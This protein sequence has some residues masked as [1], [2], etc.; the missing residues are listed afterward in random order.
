MRH[1]GFQR[2]TATTAT[3]SAAPAKETWIEQSASFIG[4][5]I[6]LLILK[7]FFLP[8]FIIPTGSMAETLYGAHART[9]CPNCGVEYSVGWHP[10]RDQLERGAYQPV[11]QCPNCRWRQYHGDAA[12]LA[13]DRVTPDG[14]LARPL[15]PSAGDRIFVHGWP[16]SEPFASI[17][18]LGPARWDVVVFKVP[19][20]GQTNYIKRL[21]GLPNEKIEIINGDL[22]VNDRLTPKTLQAQ[23]SLWFPVYSQNYPPRAASR[24]ADYY[25]RWVAVGPDTPWSGLQSRVLRCDAV[26]QPRRAIQFVTD[27]GGDPR[28][29]RIQDLYAYNE[30][31]G[32]ISPH[33]VSDVRLSAEV[34]LDPASRGGVELEITHQE[35][36][37]AASLRAD[38]VLSLVHGV[39]ADGPRETWGTVNVS[40][41]RGPLH[42]A[43]AHVDGLA[44]VELNSRPVLQS[45][46]QQYEVTADTARR[47]AAR[48]TPPVVRLVVQDARGTLR[49]VLVER[50]VFYTSDAV[51][52]RRGERPGYGEQG[53]PIRLGPAEYFVLGDNS[54]NSLDGRFAFSSP[55]RDPVGP[56][57][58]Q[59]VAAGAFQLGTVPADQM[60]G[61]AFFVY[62]PGFLPLTPQG[63]NLL[64][65]LGRARWIR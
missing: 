51:Y 2:A 58:R 26:G 41:L 33:W 13:A 48:P 35:H 17:A 5:F 30:P 34:E 65:D 29:A 27:P 46:P 22:F 21:V 40:P 15:R 39:G 49:R 6:Y 3:P 50:D 4:F 25:P 45:T 24:Q 16:F 14:R 64:P 11:V 53:R 23:R 19:T 1:R 36:V 37:F 63:P 61:R 43:L 20:D 56:H 44:R 9:M 7:T 55:G 59:A 38:G 8:L 54:P 31:R 57:L 47:W 28:P 60:I 10:A 62:W 12:R 52:Q 42:F 18:G 32:G